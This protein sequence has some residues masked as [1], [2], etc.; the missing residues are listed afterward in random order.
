MYTLSEKEKK[1]IP[2]FSLS[3]VSEAGHALFE[4]KELNGNTARKKMNMFTPHRKDFYGFLLVKEGSHRHWV[5]F[6][7]YDIKPGNLYFT[8]PNQVLLKE[9]NAPVYGMMVAFTEEFLAM[10][11]RGE[12]RNLP[13]LLNPDNRHELPLSEVD[14]HFINDLMKQM[15]WEFKT[16]GADWKNGMLQSYVNILLIY[17]SRIYMRGCSSIENLPGS[18]QLLQRMQLLMNEKITELHQVSDYAQL[19]HV[20][21]GH[22]NDTIKAITGKTATAF[23][24]ERLVLEAKRSLFYADCSVK[25]I[26]YQL[27]FE[28]AAYFNRFFKKITGETPVGFRQQSRLRSSFSSTYL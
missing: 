7:S 28:D 16:T 10:Q 11:D 18:K 14:M 19:L 1:L 22:L 24:Q 15:L 5:D 21:P 27:G 3:E 13:V 6:V 25:E 4:V 23:I 17:I 12:L 20:T 9:K 2:H 8:A 26:A